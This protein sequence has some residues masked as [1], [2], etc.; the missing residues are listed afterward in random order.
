M[1][2]IIITAVGPDKPGLVGELT[3]VVATGGGNIL[4]SRMVNLRGQ[5]AMILLVEG[6]APSVAT[7]HASL[8][9]AGDRTGLAVTVREQGPATVSV[10][11]VPYKLR[12]YSMDQPGLVHRI[13]DL[14]RA[15]GVNIE[16]LVTRQQSAAFAGTPLFIMEM[17]VTV[18][19]GVPIR[20]LRTEL[21]AACER[22][23]CDLDL[24][25]A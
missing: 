9:A 8:H 11:G 3:G 20:Q 18:P 4:D 14:L 6:D 10:Q 17:K 21:E 25:P 12:T 19:P 16:D 22:M 1:A 5:F 13:T 23:N 7:L 24:E 15:R 2:Q